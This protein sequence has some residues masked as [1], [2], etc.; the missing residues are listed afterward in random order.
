[1]CELWSVKQLK[2]M[3]CNWLLYYNRV[4]VKWSNLSLFF[5]LCTCKIN[6][7]AFAIL[8]YHLNAKQGVGIVFFF[9][10]TLFLNA[11]DLLPLRYVMS[12]PY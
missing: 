8:A 1:M 5:H 7:F 6:H 10:F 3:N 2:C 12:I 11:I 4:I 9:G